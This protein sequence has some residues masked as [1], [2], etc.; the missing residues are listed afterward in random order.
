M[1]TRRHSLVFLIGLSG[2]VAGMSLAEEWPSWRGALQN[3]VSG[4]TGLISTWSPEG[5]NLLWRQ[6]LIGR[7]T[8]VV[9]GGRVFVNGRTGEGVHRQAV[10]AAFDAED[11]SKLWEKK[12][13]LYLSTVPF[14]RVGWASLTGDPETG[15]IYA[16]L[17]NGTFLCL[18]SDGTIVWSRSFKEEF[19][20]YEGYGGRTAS[21]VIDEDR[22]VVNM[23]NSSWGPQA[24]RRHRYFAF[25]KRSGAVVWM[26][27]PGGAV[28]DLNTQSVPVVAVIANQRLL[29]AGNADGHV[30]ALQSRTGK[31]VWGFNLSKRGIN[32]SPVVHGTTVYIS[33][34]EENIDEGVLGRVVAIDAT[35]SGDVTATHERWRWNDQKVGFPSPMVHEGRIYIVDNS[36]NL[37][38]LDLE[39]GEVY[40]Q[41]SLGTVGK[42][43]PVWGDGKI[44]AP[45]TNGY[46]NILRPG[47]DGAEV[48]SRNQLHVASGRYAE[49]YGSPAVAYGRIYFTTEEGVYCLGR[50]DAPYRVSKSA[51]PA[52]GDE[53]SASGEPA[54]LL[55][56]PA[57]STL[58]PG[59]TVDFELA[60][61]DAKGR[62]LGS[63]G[64]AVWESKGV[65]S[66]I[67]GNTL[68]VTAD[69]GFESGT[70][71][72][73]VGE[74]V[75]ETRVR[76]FPGL[77]WS[78]D[79]SGPKGGYWIGGGR[80]EARSN[81]DTSV[82]V[83][84]VAAAGLLRSNL[85]IGP[86]STS[87]YSVQVDVKLEQKGRRRSDG[88][89]I[90]S[91]Y[92]LDLLGIHQRVQIRSWTAMLR[93]DETVDYS[94]EMDQWYTVLL[95]VES[96]ER[97]ALVQGKVWPRGT[98]EPA[99]WTLSVED[100][101]P[102]RQGSVGLTGYS[103]AEVSFDNLEVT[104]N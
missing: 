75:A 66:R 82:L 101:H 30:Y 56:I 33:H 77:P 26:S 73:R 10:I 69:S 9:M 52:L 32:V 17:V 2:L 6:D 88:G 28:F 68:S 85:L 16:Q 11:G 51:P 98:E 93:I 50:K 99:A 20:R 41:Q 49:L 47:A 96:D 39:T 74:L 1:K 100:P 4:E 14:N 35:G 42:S 3:G 90:N 67:T 29:I 59:Q 13:T 102:I 21:V 5:E 44:Y 31:K 40:W 63:A 71:T 22:V 87:N 91:G 81:G 62:P 78:E 79:F 23:I 25:D 34:S 97:R 7:S 45:E 92:I 64:T 86:P 76:V 54:T 43:S 15:Y 57:E 60:A 58:S 53:G 80:Y 94:L 61:F 12:F 36:A 84:P 83:K 24:A 70:L 89:V 104:E 38:A 103:G 72:A 48:L 55:V 18:D 8:P 19:G 37:A 95:R 65:T 46:F 27:A